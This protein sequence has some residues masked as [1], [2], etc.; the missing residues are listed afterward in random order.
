M[1]HVLDYSQF[2]LQGRSRA[3]PQPSSPGRVLWEPGAGNLTVTQLLEWTRSQQES[4]LW[5]A[6]TELAPEAA[7]RLG[8]GFRW[9]VSLPS[10][11]HVQASARVDVLRKAYTLARVPLFVWV[12]PTEVDDML[13]FVELIAPFTDTVVVPER[14]NLKTLE[15][16]ETL[17]YARQ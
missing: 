1:A 5:I 3:I 10:L 17:K 14:L 4:E 7:F 9:G 16:V 12:E 2:V 8:S 13:H 6:L 15:L 11:K